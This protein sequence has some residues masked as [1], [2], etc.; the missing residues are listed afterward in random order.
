MQRL[1]T[2]NGMVTR[3]VEPGADADHGGK[4]FGA[5]PTGGVEERRQVAIGGIQAGVA[6]VITTE[7]IRGEGSHPLAPPSPLGGLILAGVVLK[8]V[9]VGGGHHRL[10]RISG[11]GLTRAVAAGEEVYRT[12]VE[13]Q[14]GDIAPVDEEEAFKKHR[15]PP[16]LR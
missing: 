5:L 13:L 16:G 6:A 10:H 12:E 11:G 15:P 4:G 8:E 2:R 1:L 14:A 7:D 9:L 3:G